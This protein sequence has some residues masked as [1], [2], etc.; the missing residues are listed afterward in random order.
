[1]SKT[2]EEIEQLKHSWAADPCWDIENT[3]GFEDHADVLWVYR[4]QMEEKWS[5]QAQEKKNAARQQ[6][7]KV[8]GGCDNL[9]LLDY[10]IDLE[11]RIKALEEVNEPGL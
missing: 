6:L 11:R 5:A 8:I 9:A 10:F 7:S 2:L 3:E 4:L 1:M